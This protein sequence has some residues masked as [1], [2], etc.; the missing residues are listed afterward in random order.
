MSPPTAEQQLNFL[1]HLQRLLSEGHFVATY[2]YALLLA[3]ADIAV[4]SGDDSGRPL[5]VS[6]KQ[7][8]EKFIQYYWR[9]VVPYVPRND[10]AVSQVLRQN[11][12]RQ[13]AIIRQ[14]LEARQRSGDSLVAAQRDKSAWKSL[15][16]NVDHVVRV[17]PL[18]KLQTV[19]RSHFDFLYENRGKGTSIEL[20]PGVA[21]CLRRFYG[22]M[23]ILLRLLGVALTGTVVGMVLRRRTDSRDYTMLDLDSSASP[24]EIHQ[25]YRDLA[26]VWHPDRFAHNPRL[27]RKAD[28]KLRA[29]NAAY[30]RLCGR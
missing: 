17:M 3:L 23:G 26:Q 30:A 22:L 8:A 5:S 10:P 21:Y 7:I 12:G 14:V 16:Q 25:A 1:T 27:Q 19:G 6:T 13:A 20:Y 18:W 24:A 15:V 28:A 11:T 29:I 4:E 9:Q 2:K